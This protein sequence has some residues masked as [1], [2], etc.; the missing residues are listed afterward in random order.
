MTASDTYIEVAVPVPVH[1]SFTYLVPAHLAAAATPGKRVLIPFG[2]RRTTGY[3]IGPGE[4]SDDKKIRSILDILDVSP[5]FPE[6]MIPFFRWVADYYL[7]PIGEVI[8]TA[9]PGGLTLSDRAMVSITDAGRSALAT[10]QASPEE[11]GFLERLQASPLPQN[12]LLSNSRGSR[13][14]LLHRI[15]GRGW[16]FKKRTLSGSRTGPRLERYV[17]VEGLSPPSGKMSIQRRRIIEILR[18]S[19]E[20]PVRKIRETIPT[21]PALI[22]KMA[23]SGQVRILDRPVYRDPF[24]SPIAP[25]T[26]P[27]L[28]GEQQKALSVL[29]KGLE[30]GFSTFLMTGVTG[31]GKTEVYLQVAALALKKKMAVLILVPEIALITQMERS[32]R[33]RFGDCIAVLHSGLSTGERYDQW[34]RITRGEARIAVGARSAIFAPFR[35]VGVIVVDEEHDTSYKQESGLRYN[36]RDLAVVRAKLDGAAAILGS[37]TPSL[38]SFHNV[39]E[40]KFIE[41]RMTRRIENRPLPEIDVVDLTRTRDTRGLGRFITPRLQTAIRETLDKQE[42]ALL[43]LN[44]RGYASFPV[45]SACGS[46][47]RCRNCDISLTL[48]QASNAY[49]CHYC[50]FSRPAAMNCPACGEPKIRLMGLGTEKLEAAVKALFPGARVSRMDRDTTLRKG[51]VIRI[52]KALRKGETDILIGTQMVAKGHDFPN[53]TLVGIICADLSLSFPDFRAGERTFQLLA[54]VAGRAGRGTAPGRVILQTY[55][56]DHFSITAAKDQDFRLFFRQERISRKALH[57]PPYSRL[58]QLRISSK[59]PEKAETAAR[60]LGDRCR[61]LQ[62]EE[63]PFRSGIEILG[64]IEASLP[65]IGRRHRWQILLKGTGAALLHRFAVRLLF[66]GSWTTDRAVKVVVDVDPVAMM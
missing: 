8:R 48:H 45:C 39:A 11:S 42:Q 12:R 21:A 44:R 36:A 65:K 54:Q 41:I 34:M 28:T 19:G 3:I 40:K 33:A 31:S 10:G 53:I 58:I 15:A 27:R 64:P 20:L 6:S 18:A 29:L 52:L 23:Q 13:T 61:R 62:I 5:L 66:D 38:Q 57:Y 55:S 17:S 1:Q 46:A 35:R 4:G 24:G 37:A 59:S 51:S 50:G 22:R 2:E 25:D 32:F 14:A 9:L 43:F 7:C 56:P 26:A 47:I 16:V 60:T 49:K 30:G 63:A